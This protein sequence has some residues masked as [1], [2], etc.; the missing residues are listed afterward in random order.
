MLL[1]KAFL[2]VQFTL[3]VTKLYAQDAASSQ[4]AEL[5]KSYQKNF[6][7][8]SAILLRSETTLEFSLDAKT[9]NPYILETEHQQI[10]SLRTA[11]SLSRYKPYTDHSTIQ[12]VSLT[13][14]KGKQIPLTPICGNYEVGNIFYS[15]AK[16][17]RY[18]LH[19]A[20]LGEIQHLFLEKRHTDLKYFTSLY[21][22]DVFPVHVRKVSFIVPQWLD[23][24]LKE[25]NFD[26]YH[27]E[28]KVTA[29]AQKQVTVYEY[30]IEKLDSYKN[31]PYARGQSYTYPHIVLVSKRY[32]SNGHSYPVIGSL[33]DLYGWYA[34]LAKSVKNDPKPLQATINQLIAGKTSDEEKVKAIYFWV[35][36]H[37]RYIAFEEGIAGFKPEAAH[38]VF[39]NKYGDCKGMANLTKEMLRMAGYD[40]RLTWIGTNKIAY[41]YSLPSLAVDNHM[42]CT[43]LLHDKK[44]YLDATEKFIPFNENAERIQGRQVLIEDGESYILDRVPTGRKENNRVLVEHTLQVKE[45]TLVGSGTSEFRGEMKTGLLNLLHETPTDK[46][47]SILE[48]VIAQGDKNIAIDQL[49]SN[50]LTERVK[51]FTLSYAIAAQNQVSSFENELYLSLDYD[52]AYRDFTIAPE[53]VSEIAFNE[54]ILRITKVNFKI[55]AGYKI[56]YLPKNIDKKL[57]SFHIQV[58]FSEH[59]GEIHYEKIIAVEEGIIGKKDFSSWNQAVSELKGVYQDKIVLIKNNQ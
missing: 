12:K 36:D 22:N 21:F 2:Y 13:N 34:S 19:F 47:M 17:C 14:H 8:A 10:M 57:S 59:N 41:D 32:T 45:N 11:S 54:K 15:D 9:H 3:F 24:E 20:G 23:I 25:M 56:S 30:V 48:K 46:K 39:L 38:T 1:K 50:S 58:R 35:Q 49:V 31:E 27:I 4:N 26:G 6:K 52:Q 5:A 43:L 16:L 40:A 42:I 7:E 18:D 29:N 44:Y 37:I 53:R 28:K 33:S 51:P 55:P